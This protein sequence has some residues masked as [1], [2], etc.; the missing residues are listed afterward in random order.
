M[1]NRLYG[2]ASLLLVSAIFFLTI[3]SP[4]VSV[5]Q[6]SHTARLIEGAKKEGSLI[7]YTSTSIEDIKR[8]FDAFTKKYP[9]IK[10]EFFNAGSARVFNRILNEARAGKVFFDL[11]AVRGV[12]THQLVKGGFLQPYVSPE[13]SAY[14]Q[15]FKDTKGYWVDYFDAYNVIG[16]NTKLVPKERAPKS[17]DDLLDPQWKGKIAMDEEM[18]S[19]YAAMA[20]VWGREKAQRFM[21]ALAKQDIQ[22][23]TGQ[24]LIAQLMAA[25][26]FPMAMVLAHRIEKMKEQGAPVEWVT[27]LDP[28]TVSLHPIG[29][30]AKAP[31]SNVAKLFIDFV[32]SK[33]GQQ[34]VLAMGRTPSRPGI[35]T[36]MQSKN[37]KLFP[38]SPELGENYNRYQKE[39]SEL[40]R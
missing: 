32:L 29:V 4:P 3:A 5:A 12:E 35:D 15:G 37:L 18:Y 30:A 39:F 20:V 34:V 26:E 14:P 10:T 7:W 22:L 40:F 28:V 31:H 36:K 27:T 21:K 2:K 23:R 9:F 1:M 33:E 38:I 8:L 11:V 24:S 6:E 13:A 16:Y 19:W 25:G 17:W